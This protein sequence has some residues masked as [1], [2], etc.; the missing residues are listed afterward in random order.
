VEI[1]KESL[2]GNFKLLRR[3]IL[4]HTPFKFV[5]EN[6]ISVFV[7]VL[8]STFTDWYYLS[9]L[10][11][12]PLSFP[13]VSRE[14]GA[15]SWFFSRSCYFLKS[16]I[17]LRSSKYT[18]HILKSRRWRFDFNF[19]ASHAPKQFTI[20]TIAKYKEKI[21]NNFSSWVLGFKSY[22]TEE[23]KN[24]RF[25]YRTF[26]CHSFRWLVAPIPSPKPLFLHLEWPKIH[27]DEFS[28][29]KSIFFF[30]LHTF[31]CR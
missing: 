31:L 5:K 24:N 16:I 7:C 23:G 21:F 6:S 25:L 18:L 2:I 8:I 11:P 13:F 28:V 29:F 4:S 15:Q 10:F 19:S 26:E 27:D 14:S 1:K 12:L 9:D 20:D 30:Y 3:T 17:R 22:S